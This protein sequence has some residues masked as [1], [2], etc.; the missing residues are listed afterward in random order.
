MYQP[1]WP[2]MPSGPASTTPL[3]FSMYFLY[4]TGCPDG[5]T[6]RVAS[7]SPLASDLNWAYSSM[8]V[9][10]T[11]YPSLSS[12]SFCATA[13]FAAEPTHGLTEKL[14][15]VPLLSGTWDEPPAEEL[16]DTSL[17]AAATRANE[18]SALPKSTRPRDLILPPFQPG[19]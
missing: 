14:I 12:S 17:H 11:V 16:L 6:S 8:S 10:S 13:T 7:R 4:S 1:I 15:V 18:T 9:V 5:H 3:P 2:V 19:S